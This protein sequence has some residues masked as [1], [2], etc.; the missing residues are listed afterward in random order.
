ME[1]VFLRYTL[2]RNQYLQGIFAATR[3][4]RSSLI[5]LGALVGLPICICC[6]ASAT[7]ALK[8]QFSMEFW[9]PA[10]FAFLLAGFLLIYML[11]IYPMLQWRNIQKSGMISDEFTDE[12]TD[13][14]VRFITPMTD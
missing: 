7:T 14:Y 4:S 1:P 11:L 8:G 13:E 2:T 3:H 5:Q 6:L 12:F 10:I 9:A